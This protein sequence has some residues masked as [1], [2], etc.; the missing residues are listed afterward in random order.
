MNNNVAILK[1]MYYALGGNMAN[2]NNMTTIPELLG[3]ITVQIATTLAKMTDDI[4]SNKLP[5]VTASDNG[6]VLKVVDGAWAVG[7]DAIE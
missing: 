2:V 5:A 7:A 4:D 6:K 3:A 1:F